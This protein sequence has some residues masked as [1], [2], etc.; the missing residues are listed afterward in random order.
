MPYKVKFDTGEVVTFDKQPTD[1]DIEEVVKKHNIRAKSG[2]I[3]PMPKDTPQ[4]QADKS[5]AQQ[6]N[7]LFPA[8]T[9]ESA[10]VAGLKTA[11][12][13]PSSIL[14]FGKGVVKT[15]NPLNTVKTAQDIGT[16]ISSAQDAGVKPLDVIKGLPHATY[17]T[18]VPQ[19]F[20]NLLSGNLEEARR[21]ITNDPVGQLAPVL[22]AAKP[23]ADRLGV[24]KQFDQVMSKP[25]EITKKPVNF[26]TNKITTPL[27]KGVISKTVGIEPATLDQIIKNPDAFTPEQIANISRDSI[28]QNVKSVIDT[29]LNSLSETGKG[30]EAIKKSTQS[31]DIPKG[32]IEGI[33]AER[34]IRIEKGKIVTDAESIPM[35]AGDISAVQDFIDKFNKPN[36]SAN[37]ILNARQTLSNMSKY[38]AAKT[39]TSTLLAKE[40]RSYIDS[41]A[42]DKITG[43]SELDAQYA[44]EVKLLNQIKK[45]YLKPD[46]SFKDGAVNKIANLTGK[47]KAQVLG[48]LENITP[49]I[50]QK[51]G[52]LKA[53]EDINAAKGN[54][55]GA[56]G[57][58]AAVGAGFAGGGLL[59]AGAG[60]LLTDVNLAVTSLR[61]YGKIKN[62][63]SSTIETINKKINSA[64]PLTPKELEI[65]NAAISQGQSGKK[66]DKSV[67]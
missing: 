11:V 56:Y 51:I 33:L 60:F 27:A 13:I 66:P 49:G 65:F 34:G 3:P 57:R 36:L 37:G 54:K 58:A 24:G 41:V 67:K 62:I 20:Q 18:L 23:M 30:Y 2:I 29:R 16:E 55:V 63:S 64:M 31:V 40:L 44:P 50:T 61:S 12:N 47:G 19:F 53:I 1:A 10:L 35:S 26:V 46:G 9:G 6:F 39:G 59:G 42:K 52:I 28:S 38:D 48:R 4:Q 5:S 15:L 8:K 7:P 43:L 21:T 14:N 22:L 32:G 17:E 45:D 25:I